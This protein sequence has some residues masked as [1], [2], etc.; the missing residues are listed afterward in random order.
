MHQGSVLPSFSLAVVVDIVTELARE[1]VPSEL[2]NADNLVLMRET[3]EELR[4]N[5]LKQMTFESKRSKGYLAKTKVMASGSITKDGLSKSKVDQCGVCCLRV[6]AN[7]VLCVQC[8]DWLHGRCAGIKR[9]T[10]KF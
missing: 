3:I 6:N 5:F 10:A 1:R 9:V 7:P 2:Q 4:N 8:V